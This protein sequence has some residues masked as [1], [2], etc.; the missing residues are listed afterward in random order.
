[1]DFAGRCTY[2]L[3]VPGRNRTCN[4]RIRN[5]LLYPVELRERTFPRILSAEMLK[6]NRASRIGLRRVSACA[7]QF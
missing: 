1:M 2:E 6:F 4:L 7:A 3:S 5:P